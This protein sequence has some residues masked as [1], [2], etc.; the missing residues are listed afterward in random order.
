M[1][2]FTSI[3]PFTDVIPEP[4][5]P[6]RI[7]EG[8]YW[9]RMP[10][11]FQLDHI[12]LWVIEEEGGWAVID[13]GIRGK[14]TKEVWTA[15][16]EQL[17]RGSDR[18]EPVRLICTHV[19][20]DHMGAAGW[21]CREWG[22]QLETTKGEWEMGQVFSRERPEAYDE[23]HDF[24]HWTGCST[25]EINH[26]AK[27]IL[28]SYVMYEPLPDAYVRISEGTPIEIGGRSWRIFVG[29]GHAFEHA[30]LYCEDLN[31]LIAGDQVLPRIT[32]TV[33]LQV[34][35]PDA[36]PLS[37]FL[38]SNE[39]L[40]ALPDDIL[41]LPSHN[42]P[43]WGLHARLDQFIAH[44]GERLDDALEAC[45]ETSS[46]R[47]IADRIFT[48][49]DDPHGLFFAVGETLSHLR[50]LERQA[51]VTVETDARGVALYSSN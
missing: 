47:Q 15:V 42:T 4:G 21:F 2:K 37:D 13:S 38:K 27:H 12:N 20:P 22:I 16:F 29:L 10:L 40:R 41:V 19:H 43:F 25:D 26:I 6:F 31:I 14:L 1:S 17:N 18:K 51:K 46:A 8:L 32:P 11:P 33:L 28:G 35:F 50:Y 48:I 44:H 30:C 45:R 36:N 9:V 49:P 34:L 24:Y 39:K 5:E 23:F 3:Q 7:A